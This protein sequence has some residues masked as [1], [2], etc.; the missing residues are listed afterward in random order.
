MTALRGDARIIVAGFGLARR[1]SRLS[2]DD[3]ADAR[4][5][6]SIYSTPYVGSR[7]HLPSPSYILCGPSSSELT[8]SS[9]P[10]SRLPDS[11]PHLDP[12]HHPSTAIDIFSIGAILFTLLTLSPFPC[13][14]NPAPSTFQPHH[15]AAINILLSDLLNPDPHKRPTATDALSHTLFATH[16]QRPHTHTHTHTPPPAPPSPRRDPIRAYTPV[17]GAAA[18]RTRAPANHTA[19]RTLPPRLLHPG[20]RRSVF[21]MSTVLAGTVCAGKGDGGVGDENEVMG[22]GGFG[23][24]FGGDGAGGCRK[25]M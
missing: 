25:G 19:P 14:T 15:P 8:L 18:A 11:K 10:S 1:L 7:A 13:A 5:G 12:S 16:T 6:M 23:S 4:L 17:S 22:R 21:A 9:S 3:T 2:G 20:M 24:W